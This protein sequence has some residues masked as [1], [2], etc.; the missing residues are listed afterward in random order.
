M[1]IMDGG[2]LMSLDLGYQVQCQI[3]A[4]GDPGAGVD[5]AVFN[6]N[7]VLQH[8]GAWRYFA[9]ALEVIVVGGAWPSVQQAP[10]YVPVR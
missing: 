4:C 7:P 6:E 8:L 2:E 1:A 3:D 5:V 10:M 9:Q